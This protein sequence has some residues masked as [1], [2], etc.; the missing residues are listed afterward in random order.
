MKCC[1][2]YEHNL[3]KELGGNLPDIGDV[4]KTRTLE[5][6]VRDVQVLAQKVIIGGENEES[7]EVPI[8]EIIEVIKK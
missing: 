7:V 8:K 1:F 5:G 3:Y 4:I 6:E 2:R